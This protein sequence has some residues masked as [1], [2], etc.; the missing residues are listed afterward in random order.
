MT[1]A[2]ITTYTLLLAITLAAAVIRNDAGTFLDW[3]LG[4]VAIAVLALVYSA[5]RPST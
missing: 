5:P 3:N 4:V 2:A 1:R